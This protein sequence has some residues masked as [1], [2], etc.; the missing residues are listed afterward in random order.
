[1]EMRPPRQQPPADQTTATILAV[2]DDPIQQMLI[3]RLLRDA[4]YHVHTADNGKQALELADR[5]KPDLVLLDAQMPEM[6]GFALVRLLRHE[7]ARETLPTLMVSG[8]DDRESRQRA[9]A[10][11]VDDFIAKPV[12]RDDLVARVRAQL[13]IARAWQ[14]RLSGDTDQWP[15]R[16]R[17]ERWLAQTIET[18]AFDIWFQPIVDLRS[19]EVVAQEALARFH[20]GS[21]PAQVFE[22][23]ATSAASVAFELALVVASVTA[24][25]AFPD[26]TRLHVNVSPPTA[27]APELPELID[28]SNRQVALEI[29]ERSLFDPQSARHLRDALPA[30]SLLAADDVG[31]GYSGLSQLLDVRPDIVKIDR[32]VVAGLDADPARRALVAGLVRFAEATGSTIVGEGIE[33]VDEARSLLDLGVTTGQGYL[34]GRP[35]RIQATMGWDQ[36]AADRRGSDIETWVQLSSSLASWKEPPADSA[37]RQAMARPMPSERPSP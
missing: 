21:S 16:A 19:G 33:R 32:S 6:D 20:D 9:F 13:R 27:A 26:G 5:C 2:D 35:A 18:A 29:T 10:A 1:M 7:P 36:A 14:R 22:M 17:F 11:G 37:S 23:A 3:A 28:R 4:G 30:G 34:L 15:D 24:A 8:G 12:N 25:A 31:V